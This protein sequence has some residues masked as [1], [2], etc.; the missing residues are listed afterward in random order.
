[1]VGVPVRVEGEMADL[2]TGELRS[3]REC[4]RELL[5]ALE[6]VSTRLGGGSEL[7]WARALTERNG[8]IAQR[9]VARR[10]GVPAVAG[11]LANRFLEPWRG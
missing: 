5:D 8:A 3:T 7:E 11:W 6:P 4:L 9:E 10:D 1:M 2:Y